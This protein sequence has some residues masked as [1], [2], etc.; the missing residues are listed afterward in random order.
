MFLFNDTT[1]SRVW[2]CGAA[3]KSRGKVIEWTRT[4]LCDSMQTVMVLFTHP[5]NVGKRERIWVRNISKS[6]S[7]H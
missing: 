1:N 4:I 2:L 7:V 6:Y 3:E 5:P